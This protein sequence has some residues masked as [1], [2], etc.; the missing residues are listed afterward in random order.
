MARE[1]AQ[2][3]RAKTREQLVLVAAVVDEKHVA[4]RERRREARDPSFGG[5]T[6][7]PPAVT[8]QPLGHAPSELRDARRAKRLRKCATAFFNEYLTH[9]IRG[10][11]EHMYRECVEHLVREDDSL[12]RRESTRV[13][14]PAQIAPGERRRLLLPQSRRDLHDRRPRAFGGIRPFELERHEYVAQ[15]HDSSSRRIAWKLTRCT[16]YPPPAAV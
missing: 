6:H 2:R 15:G 12:H 9:S 8:W 16:P 13:R 5:R 11:R 14:R 10:A 7:L 1:A 4:A 3:S